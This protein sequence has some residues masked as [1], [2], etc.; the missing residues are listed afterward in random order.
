MLL[1][2]G[3]GRKDMGQMA[4]TLSGW[5]FV[6]G[7]MAH[8]VDRLLESRLGYSLLEIHAAGG[9]CV[10]FV[11]ETELARFGRP[12][13]PLLPGIKFGKG[14]AYFT[15]NAQCLG[16]LA[17][18][19][20]TSSRQPVLA[21]LFRD[22]DRTASSPRDEWR[23]KFDSVTRGFA[24]V[25]FS[26][27]VPM[28]P[29]PKSEAWLLCALKAQSY[30]GCAVLEDAPGND[31]SPRSLKTQLDDLVGGEASVE[32]QVDWITSGRFDISRIDMPS[33]DAFRNAL[34]SALEQVRSKQH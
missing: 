19:E 9:A 25:K 30:M 10:R 26:A 8:I 18:A 12:G 33:F 20:Q 14:N 34:G 6:P 16:L 3:E 11:D 32:L 13:S 21:V 24:Q 5:T 2:S 22:A 27:G 31:G 4:P 15:R 28:V 1:L 17:Q 7:P 23:M 29:R